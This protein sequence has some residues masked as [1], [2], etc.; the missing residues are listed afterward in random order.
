MFDGAE[1]GLDIIVLVG[2][3]NPDVDLIKRVVGLPGDKLEIVSGSVYI[4]D[5]LLQ[6]PYIEGEWSDNHP[7]VRI[8]EDHTS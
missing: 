4:N 8:P 1:V 6:E 5:Y 7:A 2:T 3:G